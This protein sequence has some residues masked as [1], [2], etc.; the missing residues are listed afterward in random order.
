VLPFTVT[1]EDQAAKAFSEGLVET[2]SAK[3]TRI[4][5]ELQV[6]PAWEVR[7]QNVTTAEQAAKT[8][9]VNMV[10]EGSLRQ[11]DKNIRVT[12]SLVDTRNH[13]QLRGDTVTA[14][15]SDPFAAEDRVVDSVLASLQIGL[16]PNEREALNAG[17]PAE[18][19]AYD[20]YLQGQGYLADYHKP[21][22]VQSAISV[23][24]RSLQIDPKFGLAYASLGEAYWHRYEDTRDVQF[25]GKA[26]E[27]C[28]EAAKLAPGAGHTCLGTVYNGTGRYE[29]AVQEFQQANGYEEYNDRALTGL[30]RSLEHLNRLPEAEQAFQKAITLHRN[31]WSPYTQ[32]G[33]FYYRHARYP[34]AID[35]FKRATALAPD[36]FRAWNNIA[37][38]YLATGDYKNAIAAFEKSVAIRPTAE[39]YSNLATAYFFGHH[40]DDAVAKLR[41]ALKMSPKRHDIWLNLAESCRWAGKD[42]EAKEAAQK[43]VELA[44]EA[45]RLN[46][47]SATT[48]AE[49]AYAYA[50]LHNREA[51][52]ANAKKAVDLAPDNGDVLLLA[53]LAN[54]EVGDNAG[55]RELTARSQRAGISA[56]QIKNHPALHEFAQ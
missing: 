31:Y 39:A 20:F 29:D 11:A 17:R 26:Q 35:A 19:S 9:G 4:G 53:A 43:T 42:A 24:Q 8:L 1:S 47:R 14:V 45:V 32:L 54:R 36:N 46:P 13:R 3:L 7:N 5:H 2:L 27:A 55:A 25:V 50:L 38:V 33:A 23:L 41:E 52:L 51:A 49:L 10:L 37:G 16:Q 12:Y 34:E 48:I 22:S 6:I 21:E 44:S 15:M 40:Y 28:A 56:S 18:P 30:G